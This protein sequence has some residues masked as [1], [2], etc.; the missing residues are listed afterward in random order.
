MTDRSA[1]G[2]DVADLVAKQAI[3]EVLLRYFRGIDRLDLELVRSCFHDDAVDQHGSFTG[4]PD[5]LVAWLQGLLERYDRTFHL[6]G[7]Q[8]IELDGPRRARAETYGIAVHRSAGGPD[9]LNL[10]TGFRFIDDL[11]RRAGQWAI[12]RRVA[13]TEWSRLDREGDWWAVP[14][15][16]EQGR[17]DRT[18]ALYRSR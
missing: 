7:N 18:D 8:L 6:A 2:A 11:E 16:L 1:A 13:V 12:S 14:D 15:H 4:S 3:S 10:T 5:E 17:R 9:H